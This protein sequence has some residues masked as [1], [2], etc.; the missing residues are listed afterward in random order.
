MFFVI[1]F[2]VGIVA[3]SVYKLVMILLESDTHPRPQE[4]IDVDSVI[5]HLEFQIMRAEMQAENG[6]KEAEETLVYLKEQL[7]KARTVKSKLK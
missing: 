2:L 6:I 5:E 4:K 3:Y 7:E 1:L